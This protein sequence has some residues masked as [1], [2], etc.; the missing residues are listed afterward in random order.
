MLS[1][2]VVCNVLHRMRSHEML[3]HTKCCLSTAFLSLKDAVSNSDHF[4]ERGESIG[5]GDGG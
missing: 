4:L 5:S 3:R 2:V 1:F